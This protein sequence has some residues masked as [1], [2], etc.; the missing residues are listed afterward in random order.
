MQCRDERPR[1]CTHSVVAKR[2]LA[3]NCRQHNKTKRRGPALNLPAARRCN[4]Q[5]RVN[6]R[7]YSGLIATLRNLIT[8]AP[9]CRPIGPSANRP[10][11]SC[12]MPVLPVADDAVSP[13]LLCA[14]SDVDI[15]VDV[16]LIL[17]AARR[18]PP[19]AMV[20]RII[21]VQG[22]L[23]RKPRR[24]PSARVGGAATVGLS[25]RCSWHGGH[26]ARCKQAARGLASSCACE[27]DHRGGRILHGDAKSSYINGHK[28][29]ASRRLARRR[30]HA[31][32]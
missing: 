20:Q 9:C 15:D 14:T 8:P 4:A 1:P 22:F 25:K 30:H 24:G 18:I 31:E 32:E 28:H 11:C 5:V 6:S 2:S 19:N 29:Q 23:P 16:A 21:K 10:L 12:C 27:E 7:S 17:L 13:K 26:G 3:R